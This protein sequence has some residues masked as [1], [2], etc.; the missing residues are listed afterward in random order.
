M[1]LI[2]TYM[3]NLILAGGVFNF[4]PVPWLASQ[5]TSTRCTTP[6]HKNGTCP[7]TIPSRVEKNT[8]KYIFI[9]SKWSINQV[10]MLVVLYQ[11]TKWNIKIWSKIVRFHMVPPWDTSDGHLCGGEAWRL[12]VAVAVAALAGPPE[13][14]L[15]RP[16]STAGGAAAGRS[17]S[18]R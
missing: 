8:R 12:A 15:P 2:S 10:L 1:S 16:G 13:P 18:T 11:Q 6:H 17:C 5:G 4:V 7:K 14:P 3:V 9:K